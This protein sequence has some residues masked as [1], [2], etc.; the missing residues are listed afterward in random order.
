VAGPKRGPTL[1][2]VGPGTTVVGVRFRPGT[3]P[4]VLGPPAAE[5][6]DLELDLALDLA[7]GR[8]AATLG[9]RIAE[10]TRPQDAAT[11]LERQV[12]AWCA[13]APRTDP[14]VTAAVGLLQ[15]WRT[16]AIRELTGE[17]FVSPRHLRRHFVAAIGYS[18]KTL[19]RILRFQG[20]LALTDARDAST[21]HAD[22]RRADG[23]Q[24]SRLAAAVGYADQAH[25]TRECSR[26]S[27][28]TP[29]TFLDEMADT[30]VPTHDHTPSYAPVRQ[31]L[32]RP[33]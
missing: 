11:V 22:T 14:L 16:G 7:G 19:Q 21:G 9:A 15:P 33:G 24:L 8:S 27:G 4:A 23:G 13:A 30:C 25:L 10:T 29:R 12:A 17:L 31:A 5:L 1:D 2:R 28:L 18:P 6:I 3:A 20:F 26:L 32:L